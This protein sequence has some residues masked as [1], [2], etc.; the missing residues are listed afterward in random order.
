PDIVIIDVGISNSNGLECLKQ[1]REL[2]PNVKIIVVTGYGQ[3]NLLLDFLKAGAVDFII[4]PFKADR[5][6][7]TIDQVARNENLWISLC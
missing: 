5:V 2:D 7:A 1:L 4:K 6:I 3:E